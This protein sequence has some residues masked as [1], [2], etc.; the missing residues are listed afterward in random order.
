VGLPLLRGKAKAIRATFNEF[1]R[2]PISVMQLGFAGSALSGVTTECDGVSAP[3]Y[4][5][6]LADLIECESV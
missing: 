4:R 1:P 6:T 3:R 2:L 5:K